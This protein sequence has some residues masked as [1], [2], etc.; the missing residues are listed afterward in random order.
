[1]RQASQ[2][3]SEGPAWD[4]IAPLLDEAID[5]LPAPEKS[6]VLMRY[7][8]KISFRELGE[9]FS[10]SEDAARKRV[11][12]AVE[13]L[14]LFFTRAGV[15]PTPTAALDALLLSQVVT[16]AP[17]TLAALI[18]AKATA[19]SS[20]V[21]W[22]TVL[23]TTTAKKA[24][25]I[26]IALLIVAGG[27]TAVVVPAITRTKAPAT[28]SAAPA[29]K[30]RVTTSRGVMVELLGV[31]KLESGAAWW[32]ADGSPLN[33]QPFDGEDH[34]RNQ[35]P[36]SPAPNPAR[37]IEH[38]E[39]AVHAQD[40]KADPTANIAIL[41]VF[42]I[43][44]TGS[45]WETPMP[46]GTPNAGVARI[47]AGW[48]AP[49]PRTMQVTLGIASGPW[50]TVAQSTTPTVQT[51]HIVRP[52]RKDV[53]TIFYPAKVEDPKDNP[54]ANAP[55][56]TT[57]PTYTEVEVS[58]L[59][60]VWTPGYDEPNQRIAAVIHGQ[61]VVGEFRRSGNVNPNGRQPEFRSVYAFCASPE[62]ITAIRLQIRKYEPVVFENISLRRGE[63]TDPKV[64]VK[65]IGEPMGAPPTRRRR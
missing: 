8:E 64:T 40:P 57:L 6:V 17:A 51:E 36:L 41:P 15:A 38:V 50:E 4:A 45:L 21:S 44:S 18:T 27:T 43:S 22:G 54:R 42:V 9:R 37:V 25:A 32:A 10:I 63:K 28:G 7:F 35:F 19:A 59:S 46:P 60:G 16:H 23:A 5:S 48:D 56:A 30:L 58:S 14:R 52:E 53:K 39:F 12:R 61:E 24:A 47:I 20:A 31:S 1:M 3:T 49:L 62:E 34:L 29:P 11:E 13:K 2:P 65:T 55:R 26:G 33:V